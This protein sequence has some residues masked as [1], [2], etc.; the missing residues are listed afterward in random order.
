MDIPP[1]IPSNTH[2][3]SMESDAVDR[4]GYSGFSHWK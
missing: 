4:L 3:S 1:I 2:V